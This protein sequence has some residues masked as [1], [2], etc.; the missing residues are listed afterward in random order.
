M[1]CTITIPKRRTTE[2]TRWK[3]NGLRFDNHLLD[4]RL[5]L[6]LTAFNPTYR[7]QYLRAEF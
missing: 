3:I 4:G 2:K 7:L 1:K 5:E 6:S